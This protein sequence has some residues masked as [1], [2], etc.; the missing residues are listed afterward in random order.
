[1]ICL[2]LSKMFKERI[3]SVK[4]LAANKAELYLLARPP[5]CGASRPVGN[6]RLKGASP[7]R[8]L[9]VSPDVTSQAT[10]FG[11]ACPDTVGDVKF[12]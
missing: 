8:I 10:A 6:L 5:A 4:F 3:L 7:G 2:L 1:M 11:V 12:C 9:P